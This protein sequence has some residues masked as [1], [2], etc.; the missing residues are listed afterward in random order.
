VVTGVFFALILVFLAFYLRSIDWHKLDQL[1]INWWLILAGTVIGLLFRY[2]GA[3]IWRV[4]LRALGAHE[5]PH[6]GISTDVYAQAWM[7]RYIPGTVTWIAGKVYLASTWGVS[8]SRLTVA[9]LLEGGSQVAAITFVSFILIGFSPR[10]HVL[11][12]GAKLSLIALGLLVLI[13]LIPRVFNTCIGWAFK[14]L[15]GR[16]VPDELAINGPSVSRSFGLYSIGALIS[17]L[18]C[19]LVVWAIDPQLHFSDLWFVIGAFGLATV[20]GMAA[21]FAPSGLGIRDGLQLVLLTAIMPKETALAATVL[22][23]LWSVA[24]DVLFFGLTR[25]FVHRRA[26]ASKTHAPGIVSRLLRALASKTMARITLVW[27][28]FES[29]WIALTSRYPMAFDEQQHFGAIKLHTHTWLPFFTST[30]PNSFQFGAITRDPSFLY[31]Y[32]MS[33]PYRLIELFTDSLTVQVILMRVLNIGLV[34]AGIIVFRKLLI[35]LG[36]NSLRANVLTIFFTLIPIF[37]LMAGQISYDNLVFLL[38]AVTLYMGVSFMQHFQKTKEIKAGLLVWLLIISLYASM[39]KYAFLPV[40]VAIFLSVAW[41]IVRHWT[42]TWRALA[43]WWRAASLRVRTGVIVSLLLGLGLFAGSY[44]Y[45]MV[46]YHNPVPRCDK[47]LTTQECSFY[48]PW[49]RDDVY[50]RNRPVLTWGDALPYVHQWFGQMMQETFFEV[51]SRYEGDTVV[52]HAVWPPHTLL[53]TAWVLFWLGAIGLIYNA[54]AIWQRL[55]WR[56]LFAV[57]FLYGLALFYTNVKGYMRSGVPVAIHGRYLIPLMIP[58]VGIALISVGKLLR[59]L[60]HRFSVSRTFKFAALVVVF[61]VFL[62]GGLIAFIT[63]GGDIWFWPQSPAAQH[64]NYTA[65][66]LLDPLLFP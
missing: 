41:V 1:S 37:P 66:R 35:K 7:G 6:Y 65:K 47:V 16:D 38:A 34:L 54:R 36:L 50:S 60:A 58:I 19:F 45:N 5:L 18:S 56:L 28:S 31:Y 29:L 9:S 14:V 13:I 63:S 11:S 30:P 24:V 3:Y 12:L 21:P 53:V 39:V 46:R 33:F 8:K 20:A 27:F 15:R 57:L 4:I 25:P 44:G 40:F 49:N 10:L 61:V 62:N 17:G 43:Q 51:Y 22:V 52:Y 55:D 64:V 26:T 42:A 59:D 32:V 48:A 23:R 2:F